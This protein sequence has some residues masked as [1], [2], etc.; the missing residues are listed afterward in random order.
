M[1]GVYRIRNILDN[2]RYVGS[3]QDLEEHW[4]EYRKAL[5]ERRHHNIRLQ[6]AWNKYGEENFVYEIEGEVEG[7]RNVLLACE[8]IYLDEGFKQG[9]LYNIARKAGGGNLGPEV[10]RKKSGKNHPMYGKPRTEEFKQAQ[11]KFMKDWHEENENPYKGKH[12]TEITC[13]Q[14]SEKGK[15]WHRTHEHPRGMLGKHQTEQA[16]AEI[17]KANS[18]ENNPMYGKHHTDET[19]QEQSEIR[20][21]YYKTN[22]SWWVGKHHTEETKQKIGKGNKGKEISQEQRKKLSAA[23]TGENNP[24]YGKHHTEEAK[25]KIGS[26][27]ARPY[28]AFYNEKTGEY[29]CEGHNLMKLC[30]EHNLIC[31][32]M[33]NLKSRAIKQ[34]R[35]GWRLAT[36]SEI[37]EANN[38]MVEN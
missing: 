31:D 17:G 34:T 35:E 19:K 1:Q 10:N 24:F 13:D 9:I 25:Q 16:K 2:K 29:I 7:N 37:K 20:K 38:G 18:G 21:E 12:H 6:R 11:S 15:E 14:I 23:M 3:A 28:P 30:R 4:G 27:N 33:R 36:Q 5:R 26:A 32:N 8:Q 22:T